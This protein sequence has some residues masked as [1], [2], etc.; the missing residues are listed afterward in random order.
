MVLAALEPRHLP[1]L[2]TAPKR[3]CEHVWQ[4]ERN[5]WRPDLSIAIAAGDPRKRQAALNAGADITVIGRDNLAD[6]EDRTYPTLVLDE[7]SG[8]KDRNTARWKTARRLAK[9]ATYRWGL[10]GTPTPNG[11]L[12]LWAQIFLLDQGE[13]LDTSLT[14]FRSRYFMAGQTIASGVI[15]EWLLRP[16]AEQRI[17]EKIDDI[18]LY[19]EAEGHPTTFNTVTVDLPP[20]ARKQY[21]EFKRDLVL[22]LEML[23]DEIYSAANAA[24][25]TNKLAQVTSGFLYSDDGS[26]RYVGLHRAKIDALREIVDGTGSPILVFYQYKSELK[27][28][29]QAFPQ[30]RSIDDHDTIPRW[31]RKELPMMVAH[32]AS[33]GHGLNLQYGGHVAVWTSLTWS[34]EL[35]EQANKR[36]ARQ[37]QAHPVIIHSLVAEHTVD[38]AK[39]KRLLDKATIQDALLDHL[40]S[41]V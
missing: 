26:G 23:G 10:T 18:C 41:P 19:M 33:A 35:W 6:V 12:D 13:R 21:Q 1:V 3:V 34:L 39:V 38:T 2:V 32:P 37:G 14:R 9:R 36:L 25:L 7:L 24:I 40:R 17:H 4:P 29:L 28:I 15:V 30:A 27:E 16:E 20:A 5:L 31:N 11:L 8:F 22:N